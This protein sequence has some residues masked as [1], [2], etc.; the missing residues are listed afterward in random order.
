MP[1]ARMSLNCAKPLPRSLPHTIPKPNA[2]NGASGRCEVR[3]CA[4]LT[5]IYAIKHDSMTVIDIGW[6]PFHSDGAKVVECQRPNSCSADL[7]SEKPRTCPVQPER[8]NKTGDFRAFTGYFSK[9]EINNGPQ[10]QNNDRIKPE[11]PAP[12][13]ELTPHSEKNQ[14]FLYFIFLVRFYKE[15][16]QPDQ[17]RFRAATKGGESGE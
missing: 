4:I 11:P 8:Q 9:N 2:I 17:Q 5:S 12:K 10:A 15:P 16:R 13:E 14:V 3:I 6:I 7:C 1:V